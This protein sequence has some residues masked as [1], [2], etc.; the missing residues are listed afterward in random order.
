MC[1]LSSECEL[2]SFITDKMFPK[3]NHGRRTKMSSALQMEP[4][5][6]Y[7]YKRYNIMS[8]I[9]TRWRNHSLLNR[10]SGYD[11]PCNVIYSLAHFLINLLTYLLMSFTYTDDTMT[12]AIVFCLTLCHPNKTGRAEVNIPLNGVF[13]NHINNNNYCK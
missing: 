8:V 10:F 2:H 6:D 13:Q 9:P 12:R 4:P 7:K 11:G 1:T 3:R 5:S